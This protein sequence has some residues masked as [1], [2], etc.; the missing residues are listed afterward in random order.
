MKTIFMRIA[1]IIMYGL[2][3][4]V[5]ILP[6]P[7]L[8]GISFL[9]VVLPMKALGY[10]RTVIITNLSRS[11]PEM[12]YEEIG[13]T[14]KKFY[15]YFGRLVAESIWLFTAGGKQVL[16]RFT[17]ENTRVLEDLQKKGKSVVV[18]IPHM[19]N[20]EFLR[21]CSCSQ[22]ENFCGYPLQQ[23]HMVYQQM[24]SSV[25]D[26]LMFRMRNRHKTGWHMLESRQV[27]RH[28]ARHK[29]TPG[30]YAM[31]ADQCP[32]PVGRSVA[33]HFLGQPTLMIGGPESLAAKYGFAMVYGAV[34]QQERGR[35]ALRFTF[36]TEDASAEAQGVPTQTFA[37]LL[38]K[39]IRQNVHLWL[40]SHKRWKRNK[41][42]QS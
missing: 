1:W 5:S 26:K 2:I 39:D 34:H 41:K 21:A 38:E 23:L 28:M 40:W 3:C 10:R 25:F 24:S 37:Q 29:D 16:K 4:L 11:F 13:K 22:K 7:V 27:V 30:I 42:T 32:G 17:T 36:I 31:V 9:V 19:G 35:Y 15:L 14:T 12:T 33:V 20:W 8:Y 6:L 18:M